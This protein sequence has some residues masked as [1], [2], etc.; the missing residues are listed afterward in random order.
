MEK[1]LE[2]LFIKKKF[3]LSDLKYLINNIK[4]DKHFF[5]NDFGDEY[6][7]KLLQYINFAILNITSINLYKNFFKKKL[8]FSLENFNEDQF[9]QSLAEIVVIGGI[10]E[11]VNASP[12][13]FSNFEYEKKFGL[14]KDVDSSVFWDEENCN[15][16]I[17]V[18]CPSY[19]DDIDYSK[20]ILWGRLKNGNF[21]K[22]LH[23]VRRDGKAKDY[24]LDAHKKFEGSS[25]KDVNVLVVCVSDFFDQTEWVSYYN[26]NI[27]EDY[28]GGIVIDPEAYDLKFNDYEN[29]DFIMISD[30]YIR[31]KNCSNKNFINLN[32]CHNSIFPND[33]S[34]RNKPFLSGLS[35]VEKNEIKKI[36]TDSELLIYKNKYPELFKYF[37]VSDFFNNSSIEFLE[38][39]ERNKQFFEEKNWIY[40][41]FLIRKDI[42]LTY[43]YISVEISNV[44]AICCRNKYSKLVKENESNIYSALKENLSYIDWD[45]EFEKLLNFLDTFNDQFINHLSFEKNIHKVLYEDSY[46][47]FHTFFNL[48]VNL[49]MLKL[50]LEKNTPVKLVF[51]A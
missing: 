47:E 23:V 6:F 14:T 17:E 9:F 15:V 22:E 40:Y 2:N 41:G 36:S 20:K 5:L 13:H 8:Q 35:N 43:P 34:L 51:T 32:Q 18:K 49:F 50:K 26:Q 45:R 24:L 42:G 16:N 30:V 3:E 27:S 25:N 39:Y 48:G 29:V 31:I 28:T 1:Y 11:L 46:S 44:D 38:F 10:Y 21:N 33:N 7:G 4:S 12:N 37:K 19:N